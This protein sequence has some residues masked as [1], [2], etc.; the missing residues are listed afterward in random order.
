MQSLY[1]HYTDIQQLKKG[2]ANFTEYNFCINK[3]YYSRNIAFFSLFIYESFS[4]PYGIQFI[5]EIKFN[6]VLQ[7]EFCV[8]WDCWENNMEIH[9]PHQFLSTAK[10]WFDKTVCCPKKMN[11]DFCGKKIISHNSLFTDRTK[12]NEKESLQVIQMNALFEF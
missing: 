1:P 6:L 8:E 10:L 5:F 7:N 2:W 12:K 4:L 9:W 11:G 3:I